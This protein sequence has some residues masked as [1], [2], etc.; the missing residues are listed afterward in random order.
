MNRRGC[1]FSGA[2]LIIN[3]LLSMPAEVFHPEQIAKGKTR[4]TTY[5][6]LSTPAP[7]NQSA[8]SGENFTQC[9][10][11]HNH[12]WSIQHL[13]LQIG[14]CHNTHLASAKIENE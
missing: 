6:V 7:H 2:I 4:W 5:C 10:T 3:S 9:L 13:A 8:I 12:S 14:K 1:V 11:L